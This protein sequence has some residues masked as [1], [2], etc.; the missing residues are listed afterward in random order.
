MQRLQDAKSCPLLRGSGG[1][2]S[3]APMRSGHSHILCS[4]LGVGA[5]SKPLDS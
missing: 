2:S 3:C 5:P 4:R 1:G